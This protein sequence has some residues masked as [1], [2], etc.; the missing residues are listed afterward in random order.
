M[1]R[2]TDSAA[3]Y[4]AR[5]AEY[6][7]VYQKP[8]RQADLVKLRE[9][10]AA[11]FRDRHVLEIACGTGYWTS[12]IAST[13]ATVLATDASPEVLAFARARLR[14]LPIVRLQVADAYDLDKLE[15]SFDAVLAAF[16]VSHVPRD[17]LTFFLE[18][19]HRRAGRGAR[20]LLIDNR[21]VEGSSTP[22]AFRD[23]DGNSF[24]RRR[25]AGGTEYDV[26]KNFLTRDAIVEAVKSVGGTTVSVRELQYYWVA[27]YEV[28]A[29]AGDFGDA[30]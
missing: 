4:A 30:S 9:T 7:D 20:V 11:Y 28:G 27:A 13:A 6:E 10:V 19:M 2:S 29:T 26:L 18:G 21:Y 17:R 8:E 12:V 15:G 5:V 22:I 14:S 16:W 1:T 24:Q 23:D 25:L 3:Y